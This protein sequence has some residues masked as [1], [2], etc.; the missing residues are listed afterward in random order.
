MAGIPNTLLHF[1]Y[2]N[3]RGEEHT[4]LVRPKSYE[5]SNYGFEAPTHI[6]RCEVI[7]RDGQARRG[8]RSFAIKKLKDI[9]ELPD[10]TR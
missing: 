7:Q 6:L 5:W 1:I 2:V 3:H 8:D 9:R 4:Y 10:E